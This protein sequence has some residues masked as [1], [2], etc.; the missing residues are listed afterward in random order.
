[1]AGA[2]TMPDPLT[3]GAGLRIEPETPQGCKPLQSEVTYG[4]TAVFLLI[5]L[6]WDAFQE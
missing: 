5:F 3:H 6:L 1:M 2:T 4:V